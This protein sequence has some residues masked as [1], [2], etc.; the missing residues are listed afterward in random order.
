MAS[1]STGELLRAIE[2][3]TKEHKGSPKHEP[4]IDQ[5]KRV[6]GEI[7]KQ[8]GA[9]GDSPG[10]L[11]AASAADG[12]VRDTMSSEATQPKGDGQKRSNEPGHAGAPDP[13]VDIAGPD[14]RDDHLTGAAAV[15]S[16]GARRSNLPSSGLAPGTMEIRR[17]AAARE[18]SRPDTHMKPGAHKPGD[19]NKGTNPAGEGYPASGRTGDVRTAPISGGSPTEAVRAGRQAGTPPEEPPVRVP[20][21]GDPFA[22]AREAAKKRLAAAR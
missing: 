10:K 20:Q 16:A 11:A 12:A 14:G 19:D 13:L 18:A 9:G 4:M 2:G 22:T 21:Q 1:K 8:K 3:F 6:S 17:I 7:G 5:L 15:N